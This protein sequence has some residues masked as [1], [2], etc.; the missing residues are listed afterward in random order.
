MCLS[1]NGAG[2]AAHPLSG[3]HQTN[4]ACAP[5]PGGGTGK[6][7]LIDNERDRP[8]EFQPCAWSSQAAGHA[9]R[10][11]FRLNNYG[12]ANALPIRL[13]TDAPFQTRV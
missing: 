9:L 1:L 6:T 3:G 2:S 10:Q 13:I 5:L 12:L 11:K 8:A 7:R 4:V